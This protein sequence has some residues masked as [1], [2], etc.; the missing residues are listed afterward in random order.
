MK[1]FPENMRWRN[2]KRLVEL[3]DVRFLPPRTATMRMR[4]VVFGK[5]TL[6]K[7]GG[8]GGGKAEEKGVTI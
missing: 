4:W 7:H 3:D 8:G 2:N 5:E 6:T 1:M